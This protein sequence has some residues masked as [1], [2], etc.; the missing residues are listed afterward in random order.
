MYSI[1]EIWFFFLF[2]ACVWIFVK[3]AC[4]AQ[5]TDNHVFLLSNIV[6]SFFFLCVCGSVTKFIKKNIERWI[7]NHHRHSTFSRTLT[8]I[9]RKMKKKKRERNKKTK[10]KKKEN[11]LYDTFIFH[12]THVY[13]YKKEE[14][15]WYLVIF[16]SY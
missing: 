8:S 14:R 2:C 5:W 11:I 7:E 15:R 6:C 3:T 16:T 9:K 13:T 4:C 12:L 1:Q 10:Q